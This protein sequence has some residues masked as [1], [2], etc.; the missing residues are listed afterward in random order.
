MASFVLMC[1]ILLGS[2]IK[3]SES[4]DKNVRDVVFIVAMIIV[5]FIVLMTAFV[6]GRN[7]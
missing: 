2:F 4:V 5:G 6:W 7:A 3:E 1:V